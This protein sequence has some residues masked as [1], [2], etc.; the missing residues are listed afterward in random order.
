MNEEINKLAVLVNDA[1]RER[2]F[3]LS[4]AESCTG[5]GVAAAITSVAGSSEVFK[6]GVVAYANEVKHDVLSVSAD[7]LQAFGAVSEAV[8]RQMATGVA[9][10]MH[11]DCAI[12]TSG[13]AGPGGGSPD[14]PV[15]TVWTAFFVNGTVATN[16]LT[17]KDCGRRANIDATILET[18]KKIH[19]L[20]CGN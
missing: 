5:G 3:T 7:S 1:L 2:G 13:I 4:V 6:G 8:V 12:A 11:T 20:L 14:K 9:S 19:C 17:L 18:L 15:G 10:L 16:K